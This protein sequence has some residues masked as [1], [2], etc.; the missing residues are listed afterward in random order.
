MSF[1]VKKAL[2]SLA[3][4]PHQLRFLPF[5]SSKSPIFYLQSKSLNNFDE[6]K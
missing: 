6:K 3:D 2:K 4:A 5:F 1:L